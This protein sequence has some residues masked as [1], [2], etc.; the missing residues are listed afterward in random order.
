[1][2]ERPQR[3]ENQM[4]NQTI[5]FRRTLPHITSRISS[6]IIKAFEILKNDHILPHGWVVSEWD[7]NELHFTVGK[8]KITM[9][10]SP[11]QTS[12]LQ[13]SV[14]YS[15]KYHFGQSYTVGYYLERHNLIKDNLKKY[16]N[17]PVLDE[18]D[19]HNGDGSFSIIF[20]INFEKIMNKV[21][22]V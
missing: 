7:P 10:V 9:Y 2:R 5:K 17:A 22:T 16:F 20:D 21:K 15:G 18:W 3:K 4:K 6:E 13:I 11:L 12:K 14:R 1:M 8:D 19:G